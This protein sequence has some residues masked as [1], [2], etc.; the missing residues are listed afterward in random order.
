SGGKPS[1]VPV[2][3]T[4]PANTAA[5]TAATATAAVSSLFTANDA[6]RVL[7]VKLD[8]LT[9]TEKHGIERA[10]FEIKALTAALSKAKSDLTAFKSRM[11]SER[12]TLLRSISEALAEQK[13]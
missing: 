1:V 9:N 4:T 6:L 8:D 11:D 13:R 7:E 5:N 12:A 10:E 2:P 3:V